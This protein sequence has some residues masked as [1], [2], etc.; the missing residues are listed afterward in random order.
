MTAI[1]FHEPGII[2]LLV[3][4]GTRLPSTY[5]YVVYHARVTCAEAV[6]KAECLENGFWAEGI[7]S[8]EALENLA[9][10]F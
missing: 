9:A 6:Y 3:R 5:T 4:M 7:S 2:H 10:R 1:I 8:K